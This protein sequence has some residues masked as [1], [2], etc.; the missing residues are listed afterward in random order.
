MGFYGKLCNFM[1]KHGILQEN[2]CYFTGDYRILRD[3]YISFLREMTGFNGRLLQASMGD[4]VFLREIKGF[5]G[6]LRKIMRF[7]G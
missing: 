5:H 4:H 6:I 1:V 3:I 7:S 2:I